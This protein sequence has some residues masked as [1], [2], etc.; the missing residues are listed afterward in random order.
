ML[1]RLLT[2][3]TLFSA[4]TLSLQ[5]QGLDTRGYNKDDWEEINFEFDSAV[6]SD[7]FPSLLRLAELLK[8]HPGYKVRLEGHTDHLGDSA[9]NERLATQRANTV[10]DFLVKYG[11]SASQ[12]ATSSKAEKDPKVSGEKQKYS[13][14][15]VARWMNRRVAVTVLDEKGNVVGAGGG[16]IG[17]AIAAIPKAPRDC[18][19]EILKRLDKL[20]EIAKALR[21]LAD[22]N[23]GLRKELDGLKQ[24]QSALQDK[25]NGQPKGATPEQVQQTVHE[26]IAKSKDPRFALLGVNIGE[27][28]YK[29][30]TFSGRARYFAPFKEH[31]ALQAQ[32]EYMYFNEASEGQFD[33]GLVDR[34][35]RFQGGLFSSFKHVDLHQYQNGGTLGQAALTMD[36]I[37]KQGK[38]GLFGTKGFLDNALI[39]SRNAS[40][41]NGRVVDS[42]TGAA[43]GTCNLAPNLYVEHLLRVVDQV[44]LSTTLGLWKNNYLEANFGYMR[45]RAHADR[46][47]G[48]LRFIFPVNNKIA[49]TVEGGM[50]ESL[51]A[52]NNWGR[53]VVGVQFGNF[54]RPKEYLNVD[55]PVPVDVPRVRYEVATRMVKRGSSPPIADAGPDQIGVPSGTITLNGSGSYDP[56]GEKL[57]YQWVAESGS[58]TINNPTS[59]V[60]TFTAAAGQSY[61]FRLTVRNEDG[62]TASA[63]TRVTTTQQDK[64]Q[65]VFFTSNPGSINLG[66]QSTLA[67]QVLNATEVTVDA[68]GA[69]QP[70]GSSSVSPKQ[71]TTYKLTARNAISEANAT[72]TVV[73]NVQPTA[74]T[75][76]YATPTNINLGE[77]ATVYFQTTNATAVTVTPPVPGVG[78][79]GSFVVS[80]TQTTTYTLLATGAG[81]TSSCAV[82]VSVNTGPTGPPRIIKFTAVPDSIIA[83]EKSTLLWNVENADTVTITSLGSVQLTGTQDV[84]PM[85]TTNYIL[86]ATN[87]TGSATAQAL[88]TVGQPA[89]ITSFTA[90][91]TVS[92]TPGANVRLVCLAE[93][94]T[95]VTIAGAGQVATDGSVIV[96]PMVDTTYTC[97]AVGVRSQ[98][99]KTLIVKVT[100]PSNPDPPPSGPPPTVVIKGGP[101]METLVRTVSLDASS[102]FSSAGY[103]PLKYYWTSRESRAAIANGNT[104]TPIVYLGNLYGDYFFDVTVT[105][106]RGNVST[107]TIDV[108]LVVT[109][110]P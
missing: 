10:R 39:D 76:C 55:H 57:T 6:L 74:F 19:D 50:N 59:A 51:I 33:V 98:D 46:P 87:K 96:N 60:A 47:G 61:S 3:F 95:S 67:W 82:T 102:S 83:G 23:A 80:P 49:F 106:A 27:D 30:V 72:A 88:V 16:G 43:A 48:T 105:D 86:T 18:C 11:A 26:E 41:M 75:A 52:S 93:N 17:D 2:L 56:N 73:V 4:L 37:F 1:K 70:T 100:Q 13:K 78:T 84:T 21:D 71:T 5:A 45:S 91:P 53:A 44:G 108:R 89:R 64:V 25:V 32:G 40:V 107:G 68:I 66:Q 28:S 109:R 12:I 94:A 65:I 15:D 42:C 103:G 36:Y 81:G 35:G 54:L 24:Q 97:T 14:T 22:Q 58:V 62:L 29:H 20:D 69:V 92:P 101:V 8:A 85:Q 90:T 77:A 34:I 31:F 99:S 38:I 7:G 9:Y 63:R 79:S 104:A 110:I